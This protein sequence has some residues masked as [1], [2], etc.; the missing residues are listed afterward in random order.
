LSTFASDG[1]NVTTFNIC[2]RRKPRH[3]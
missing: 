1:D 2:K 3:E